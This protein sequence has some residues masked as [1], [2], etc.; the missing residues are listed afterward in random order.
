VHSAEP[1]LRLP[2]D[3]IARDGIRDKLTKQLAEL[4]VAST[5]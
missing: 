1:P 2:L 3:A 5:R 4:D